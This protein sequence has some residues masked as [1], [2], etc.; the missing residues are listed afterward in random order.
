MIKIRIINN[1]GG[2]GQFCFTP[3]VV[4]TTDVLFLFPI[5][6]I[7]LIPSQRF[8]IL[9][10][11]KPISKFSIKI[12]FNLIQCLNAL[13]GTGTGLETIF[14]LFCENALCARLA[15]MESILF[16]WK[17]IVTYLSTRLVNILIYILY[18]IVNR[19]LSQ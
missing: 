12:S 13:N 8:C 16:F 10:V 2:K 4:G 19:L 6:D 11:L 3:R 7:M 9:Q 18:I 5:D 1:I 14:F 17:T 15:F